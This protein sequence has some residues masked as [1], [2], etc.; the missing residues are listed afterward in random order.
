[1]CKN[2]KLI[3]VGTGYGGIEITEN[4][5]NAILTEIREKAAL[6]DK[7]YVGEITIADVP[8]DWQEEIQQRVDKRIS[9][10]IQAAIPAEEEE[11]E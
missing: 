3:A 11:S 7:L 9:V 8:L 1:M 6:E 4:E 5:Y 10:N 2:N